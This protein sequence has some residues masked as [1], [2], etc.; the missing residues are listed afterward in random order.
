MAGAALE[1]LPGAYDA[2]LMF[3]IPLLRALDTQ[4]PS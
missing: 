2:M 1:R 4:S 3:H